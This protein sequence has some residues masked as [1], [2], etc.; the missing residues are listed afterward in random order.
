MKAVRKKYK[1]LYFA[2]KR[3]DYEPVVRLL[4]EKG[5]DINIK[6]KH[7]RTALIK[8]KENEYEEVAQLLTSA[9]NS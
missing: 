5:A 8:V 2:E 1:G 9:A 6:D 4:L 3:V 7:G